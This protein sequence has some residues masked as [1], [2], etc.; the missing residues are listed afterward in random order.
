MLQNSSSNF[1]IVFIQIKETASV[2]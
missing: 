1:T 2:V